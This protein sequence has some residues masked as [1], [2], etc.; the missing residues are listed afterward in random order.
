M[1]GMFCSRKILNVKLF[2]CGYMSNVKRKRNAEKS[3]GKPREI[4]NSWETPT[5]PVCFGLT[6]YLLMRHNSFHGQNG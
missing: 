3:H 5:D 6:C 4:Q 2:F 1:A